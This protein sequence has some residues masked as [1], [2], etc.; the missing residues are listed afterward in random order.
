VHLDPN[1]KGSNGKPSDNC[2]V[3]AA[4]QYHNAGCGITGGAN[5]YG[6]PF[7]K[8]QGGV[9]VTEWTT[10]GIQMWYS[11]QHA[12]YTTHTVQQTPCSIRYTH[13]TAYTMQ[14]TLHTQYSI[15]HAAYATHRTHFPRSSP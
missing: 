7:N 3:N 1:H 9:Y 14:H 6:V 8:A 2:D 5:T 11:I 4:G 13:S 15:H 12:A 10:A